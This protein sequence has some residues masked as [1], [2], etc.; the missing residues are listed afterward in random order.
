MNNATL[1]PQ[2]PIASL[3]NPEICRLLA[4]SYLE[5]RTVC[6]AACVESTSN[7]VSLLW[8]ILPVTIEFV[9]CAREHNNSFAIHNTCWNPLTST[10]NEILLDIRYW[11]SH[12]YHYE[13]LR[14]SASAS[15]LPAKIA[16]SAVPSLDVRYNVAINSQYPFQLISH[17]LPGWLNEQ[18]DVTV[19]DFAMYLHHNAAIRAHLELWNV[20]N[21]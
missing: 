11:T 2:W 8:Y 17:L 5:P 9:R 3:I 12:L 19:R 14:T 1:W 20:S 6:I 21:K 7:Q 10:D 18:L 15:K 16:Y 13:Q 4:V